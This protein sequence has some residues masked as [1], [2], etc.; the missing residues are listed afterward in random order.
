MIASYDPVAILEQNSFLLAGVKSFSL[1]TK[2]LAPGNNFMNSS[3]HWPTNG[4]GT[5][6]KFFSDNFNLLATII[7]AIAVYV[8]P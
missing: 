4:F 2:M 3:P 5:T 8:F 1:D 7:A 6:N